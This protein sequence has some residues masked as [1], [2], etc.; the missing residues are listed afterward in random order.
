MKNT[1]LS[2]LLAWHNASPPT[3]SAPMK[4]P[5]TGRALVRVALSS[6]RPA[7]VGG[8]DAKSLVAAW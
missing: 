1:L 7:A 3:R 5:T 8:S 4:A 2:F 6:V